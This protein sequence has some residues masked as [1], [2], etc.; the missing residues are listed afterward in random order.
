MNFNA[1]WTF[2]HSLNAGIA[3]LFVAAENFQKLSYP[4][5]GEL[6]KLY[7]EKMKKL[8]FSEF[9]NKLFKNFTSIFPAL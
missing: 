8:Q 2:W 1:S 6:R 5:L 9:M 3:D 4:D 7:T